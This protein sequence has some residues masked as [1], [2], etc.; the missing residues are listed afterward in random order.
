MIAPAPPPA[1]LDEVVP[2]ELGLGLVR[3]PL[4]FNVEGATT[5]PVELTNMGGFKPVTKPEADFADFTGPVRP[6][7]LKRNVPCTADAEGI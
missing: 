4:G 1:P 6:M 5:V 7:L 2:D 3:G